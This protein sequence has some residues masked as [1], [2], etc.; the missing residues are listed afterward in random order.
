MNLSRNFTLDEFEVSE[1]AAR[2]G[3][4]NAAPPSLIGPITYVAQGLE[5]VRHLCGGYPVIITSGYRCPDLNAVVGGSRTS[6]HMRGEAADFIIPTFGPALMI[7]RLLVAERV[8]FDQLIHEY[9]RWVHVSFVPKQS[10]REVLTIDAHG[11]RQGLH[12]ARA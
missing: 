11:T 7:C 12:E 9:G 5:R 4:D 2:R 3:I 10:R 6:Q 8:V 1:T